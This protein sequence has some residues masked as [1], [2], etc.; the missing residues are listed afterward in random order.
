MDVKSINTAGWR[1]PQKKTKLSEDT[2]GD[3]GTIYLGDEALLPYSDGQREK[4][5]S[6][7][8]IDWL[9]TWRKVI[10]N[11]IIY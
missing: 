1:N 3:E 8:T 6:S 10:N 5:T 2:K 4:S 11:D 7:T 9:L